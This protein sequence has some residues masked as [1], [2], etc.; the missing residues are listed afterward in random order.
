[1]A[2]SP[3]AEHVARFGLVHIE[4][5]IF[6]EEEA[7]LLQLLGGLPDGLHVA[8]VVLVPLFERAAKAETLAAGDPVVVATGGSTAGRRTPAISLPSLS[9]FET[10]IE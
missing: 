4:L 3:L 2:S 5:P 10:K 9:T 8:V 6:R 7:L 1:M